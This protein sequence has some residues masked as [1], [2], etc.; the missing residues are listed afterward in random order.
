VDLLLEATHR[1]EQRHFWFRGFRRFVAPVVDEAARGRR[2]LWLLDCGCGT[3]ANLGWLERYGRAVG[4]DVTMR[5]LEFARGSGRTR[6]V[7]ATAV[8]LPF[9]DRRFDVV[10]SFDV[11]YSLDDRDE[12]RAI[13]EMA[14]VL[15]PGGGLVVNVAALPILRG[16]HSVLALER[17][18]YTRRMLRQR[19]ER[20]GFTVEH[21]TYTNATLFP[22]TLSIRLAQRAIGFAE[23]E[24]EATAEI[25]V[26]PAPVNA[27]L[28]GLLAVE[29]RLVRHVSL[30]FGSSLLCLARRNQP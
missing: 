4:V 19:L 13:S 9:P 16:N 11:I 27:L 22:L 24:A 1:A 20:A 2:D 14:R 18:R 25:S 21:V 3:G 6:L 17:R 10:T 23:R 29:A 28:S 12:E 8:L 15:R 30:P 5:G 7:R 26:P